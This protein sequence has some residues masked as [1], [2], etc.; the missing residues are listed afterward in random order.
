MKPEFT[1]PFFTKKGGSCDMCLSII[2]EMRRSAIEPISANAF[3]KNLDNDAGIAADDFIVK[4]QA[5]TVTTSPTNTCSLTMRQG[6]MG[7]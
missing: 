1:P 3:D 2:M 7:G 6:D 4:T 5:N